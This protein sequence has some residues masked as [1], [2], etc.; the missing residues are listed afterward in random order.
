MLIILQHFLHD[1][2]K[3]SISM[4][5]QSTFQ[6]RTGDDFHLLDKVWFLDLKYKWKGPKEF[7]FNVNS[8]KKTDRPS[9]WYMSEVMCPLFQLLDKFLIFSSNAGCSD[10]VVFL[11]PVNQRNGERSI[12]CISV[13]NHNQSKIYFATWCSTY[14]NICVLTENFV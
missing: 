3:H 1:I 13:S 11:Q 10:D 5:E 6:M 7:F 4:V 14:L 12:H 9:I 8:C 2:T